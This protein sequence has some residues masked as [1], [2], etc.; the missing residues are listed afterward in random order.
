MEGLDAHD[1]V[2]D[3]RLAS[4]EKKCEKMCAEQ[5]AA[6]GRC[7][8]YR[9]EIYNQVKKARDDM[10]KKMKEEL[11]LKMDELNKRLDVFDRK[12][13]LGNGA[14]AVVVIIVGIL[15]RFLG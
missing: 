11:R 1:A 8:N 13:L 7:E 9:V 4:L 5:S 15:L 14:V 6:A 12:S 3:V 10:D 2:T